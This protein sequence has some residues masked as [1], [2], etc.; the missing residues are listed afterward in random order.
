M[1]IDRS[2]CALKSQQCIQSLA[3]GFDIAAFP[4]RLRFRYPRLQG[5]ERI[6]RLIV[7]VVGFVDW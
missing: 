5:R 1:N 7:H 3:K 6:N 4:S 2:R